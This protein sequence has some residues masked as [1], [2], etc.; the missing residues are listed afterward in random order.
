MGSPAARRWWRLGAALALGLL[1]LLALYRMA[2]PIYPFIEDDALISL[3]YA[4]RLL[5]GGGLTW[6]DGEA[7]EGYSNLLW[8]LLSAALGAFGMDLVLAVR[9]LGVASVALAVW[10]LARLQP[11][12]GPGGPLPALLAALLLCLSGPVALWSIGGLEQPL[13]LGLLL[14]ALAGLSPLLA[15]SD[16]PVS[17]RGDALRAGL[18][19][20]VPLLLMV[21]TRPDSPLFVAL[22][23]CA[24]LLW[25]PGDLRA[26][27][28][29]A[30]VVAGLPAAGY[31]A[32]LAF[33]LAYYGEAFPNTAYLK[34]AIRPERFAGGVS[35]LRAGLAYLYPLCLSALPGVVLG[36]R[37]PAT[38]AVTVLQLA[39][40]FAW[41]AYVVVIGGDH[42]PGHRHLLV[43]L[44]LLAA[45][46]AQGL[47]GLFGL[48]PAY[49]FAAAA[50]LSIALP[51]V[52]ALQRRDPDY[53]MGIRARWQWDGQALGE[54]V[55]RGVAPRR[56][57]WAV[58][59][60]GCL[61]Y[62]SGLPALDML[63]L[64]DHHIARQPPDPRMPLAHDHGDGGYVLDRAPDL[65][66]FGLPTGS[67]PIYVSGE[68]MRAD[69]RFARDYR[70]VRVTTLHP[71]YVES[72][73]YVRLWG[74][75]GAARAP[76]H[77]RYPGYLL[78]G[79]VVAAPLAD[80]RLGGWLP[81]RAELRTDRIELPAGRWE[82]HLQPDDAAI[83]LR[84]HLLQGRGSASG[85]GAPTFA[86]HGPGVVQ[87]SLRTPDVELPLR[88]IAL[89]RVGDAPLAPQQAAV[90]RAL[91]LR[92]GGG[93]GGAPRVLKAIADFEHGLPGFRVVGDAMAVTD[94]AIPH[95]NPVEGHHYHLLNSFRPGLGDRAVGAMRSPKIPI[96]PRAV[97]SLR[98][99]GGHARDIH[100]QVGVA[101][102]VD[103]SV[104]RVLTGNDRERLVRRRV[105][106]SAHAGQ[107]LELEIFDRA[108][109]PFGHVLV[110]EVVLE[111]R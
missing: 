108:R 20:A 79:G 42:F 41:L 16:A 1:P 27:F 19:A 52:V 109:G 31:L 30:M 55:A 85:D 61:P 12:S 5:A 58:T 65:I 14:S 25:S 59:A 73:S 29:L 82:V 89:R 46:T 45:L 97:L 24:L 74:E 107:Q 4:Q 54:T 90:S 71:H 51:A 92:A 81:A 62:F 48:R 34:A 75:M 110:D 105:D 77:V 3:R 102:W 49:G 70:A 88:A 68:Q 69:P 104:V 22:S 76:D 9:V 43:V 40:I 83:G 44:G 8:V 35:Y 33:R 84:L 11:A 87:L 98:I 15:R 18:P 66:T 93:R 94:G 99:G 17:T 80:G 111:Q 91:S 67:T 38:R 32:Q 47:R 50:L 64:N 39:W 57:L 21:W 2:A 72:L 63:G 96:P 26:R 10:A 100:S 103:G 53:T 106:L 60:A 95:Q 28:R 23:A 56:P 101:L 78:G 13:L 6:N 7:V 36:L 37:R 86:L